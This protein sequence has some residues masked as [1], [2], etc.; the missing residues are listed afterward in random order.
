MKKCPPETDGFNKG[1]SL[2]NKLINTML[3]YY[4]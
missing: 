3:F 1:V 2:Y 4:E